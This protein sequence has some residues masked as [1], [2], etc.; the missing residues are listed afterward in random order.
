[1]DVRGLSEGKVR[2]LV[3]GGV[4]RGVG[5][6]MGLGMGRGGGDDDDDDHPSKPDDVPNLPGWGPTSWGNLLRELS[7]VRSTPVPLHRVIWGMG[8]P[9]VGEGTARIIAGRVR[10]SGIDLKDVADDGVWGAVEGKGWS[11]VLRDTRGI[12][13]TV[14]QSLVTWGGEGGNVR[15]LRRVLELVTIE[16]DDYYDTGDDDGS[17]SSELSSELEG[18]EVVFTGT[19]PVSRSEAGEI[20]RGRFGAVV[21]GSVGGGR[22]YS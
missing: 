15:D 16:D 4:V 19:L 7:R 22:M 9:G 12:G 21:K 3:E 5:D 10:E 14:V 17:N 8:I 18:M 2:S 11:E 6:L 1:M 13:D 20:A